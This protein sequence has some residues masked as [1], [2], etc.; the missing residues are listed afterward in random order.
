MHQGRLTSPTAHPPT[1]VLLI[2]SLSMQF[3]HALS[4]I[5]LA[6]SAI[7][8]KFERIDKNN[9]AL[10]VV[11]HQ[12]GLFHLVR[13]FTPIEMRNNIYAHAAIGKVF[14]LPVVMTTSAQV[15]ETLRRVFTRRFVDHLSD[16][17]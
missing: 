1:S 3:L 11:D 7:A 4:A 16:R 10:L 2:T 17:P 8:Y 5:L 13:D 9:A 15:G 6:T 14:N 12:V